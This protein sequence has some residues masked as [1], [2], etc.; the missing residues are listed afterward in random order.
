MITVAKMMRTRKSLGTRRTIISRSGRCSS[1]GVCTDGCAGFV[2]GQEGELFSWGD[3]KYWILGHGPCRDFQL[4]PKRVEALRGVRVSSVAV[5][6]RHALAL[7]EEGLV[8]S[9]GDNSHEVILGD[10][11]LEFEEWPKP[12]EALRGVRVSSVAASRWRSYAVTDT[13][14]LLAWGMESNWSMTY[15]PLGL[16][17]QTASGLPVRIESL[18]GVKV[19]MVATGQHHTLALADDGSL[20]SWGDKRAANVGALGLGPAV[21]EAKVTVHTPQRVPTG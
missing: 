1:R 14:E 8:Y 7:T 3:S 19:D 21:A 5:G 16:G 6:S 18:R 9:W 15:P 4:W 20:Y 10:P 2:I 17:E 13:G 12:V 11:D